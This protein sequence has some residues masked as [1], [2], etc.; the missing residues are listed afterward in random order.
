MPAGIFSSAQCSSHTV[1]KGSVLISSMSARRAVLSPAKS[2]WC[3]FSVGSSRNREGENRVTKR[4]RGH[5]LWGKT[6]EGLNMARPLRMQ[7]LGA[8]YHVTL[9]GQERPAIF[10]DNDHDGFQ[11]LP[12]LRPYC[13]LGSATYLNEEGA[14][15]IFDF[16]HL[17]GKVILPPS[18]S[19]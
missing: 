4:N 19:N 18:A 13:D 9:R 12:P 6:R 10:S 5:T 8:W 16:C 1:A 7:H 11:R 15:S 14:F 2:S 17:K 3:N